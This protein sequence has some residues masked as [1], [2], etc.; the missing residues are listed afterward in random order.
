MTNKAS[1]VEEIAIQ[2][3]L[4]PALT[5]VGANKDYREFRE[6]L[7]A[8]ERALSSGRLEEM[9]RSFAKEGFEEA[10]ARQLRARVQFAVK[11]LRTQTLRML[12]GNPGYREFSRQVASSDLLADF[13]RARRIDG[14]SGVSKSTLERAS[15]FFS[16]EQ[17]R[18][19]NQVLMEMCG[20]K[21]RAKELGLTE[22]VEMDVCLIDTTCLEANIHHPID[23]VLLRDVSRTLLK[24]IDLIRGAGL[25]Q[26]MPEDPAGFARRMNRLCLEMTHTR[27]KADARK[28]R[29][30]VLRRMK[31]L[32]KT[33]ASH[34]KRHRDRL[35]AS[36]A[37]TK[38]TQAQ[39]RRI[40]E[41]MDRMLGQVPA[42]IRQ[43]HERLI[44]E[45]VVASA[46]KILSVHEP[47]I[48]VLV[49]GKAGKEVEFGNTLLLAETPSGLIVDWEVYRKSAPA[50]WRQLQQSVQRQN[51]YD[52]SQ[53]IAAVAADR[54]F[55]ARQ[56][57]RELAEQGIYDAVCPKDPATLKRRFGEDR[58]AR[59]QRRRGSTE[60]RIAIF[61]QRQARRL[62]ER[63]F[64]HR[65]LAVAWGVLGHN[66]WMV[67]RMRLKQEKDEEAA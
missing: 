52:L 38:Y 49:R 39:A 56:G 12:L 66:L 60:A 50:E 42:V 4:R 54:G 13:C 21:D 47:D 62:R 45:R 17:T 48:N 53:S 14:I 16:A 25:C 8:V 27:R 26:R 59:L 1:V 19:M 67:A 5:A 15:K 22:A 7:E 33:I 58:F 64:T 29:K 18:W 36:W 44:G 43:A 40:V 9:A 37:G 20:E 28:A 63:G 34:G 23:W 24:A 11:A 30:A 35:E 57:E 65:Y 2:S 55:S 31:R 3:W 41:R 6:Q 32:V 51:Q 46:E 10:G 61:K